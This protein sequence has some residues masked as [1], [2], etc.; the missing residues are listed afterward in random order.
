[1]SKKL[2][3][4][5]ARLAGPV[6]AL[7]LPALSFAATDDLTGFN[8]AIASGTNDGVAMLGTF[9]QYGVVLT[10]AGIAAGI[11]ILVIV[12]GAKKGVRAM[13]GRVGK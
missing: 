2:Y 1:M 9:S 5:A 7:A 3:M 12:F 11:V 13:H 8:T 10:L 6:V 4:N